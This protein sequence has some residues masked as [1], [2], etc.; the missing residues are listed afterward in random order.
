M[1]TLI[2]TGR[3]D[4]ADQPEDLRARLARPWPWW[5]PVGMAALAAARAVVAVSEGNAT[6]AVGFPAVAVAFLVLLPLASR[7]S[8]EKR[9]QPWPEPNLLWK[10]V[11]G[12]AL[13]VGAVGLAVQAIII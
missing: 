7:K 11:S 1:T 3:S 13:V 2:T 5:F 6:G 4:M 9:N 12:I 10:G 8:E